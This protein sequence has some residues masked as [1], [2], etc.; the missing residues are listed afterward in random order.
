MLL[1]IEGQG[2]LA[3]DEVME[4]LSLLDGLRV[5]L[6]DESPRQPLPSWLRL[7]KKGSQRQAFLLAY[8][9]AGPEGLTR[10]QAKDALGLTDHSDCFTRVSELVEG[11]FLA[12][13]G[14]Q[15]RTRAGELASVVATTPKAKTELNLV[16]MHWFPDS[17]RVSV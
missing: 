7:P 4:A 14:E 11:G 16:S 8:A 12:P 2:S 1:R 15:R 6:V 5:E 10:E 9:K 17:K 3:L 13:T